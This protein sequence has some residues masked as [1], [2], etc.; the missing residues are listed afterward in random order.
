MMQFLVHLHRMGNSN[1]LPLNY[2]YELSS[3]IYRI[4]EEADPA[5]SH[6]LHQEGFAFGNK[7][8]KPFTFSFLEFDRFKI[9]KG[10]NRL[11][12]MGSQAVLDIRFAIDRAAEEFIKGL[13]LNQHLSI[14]DRIS[15]VDYEI[16]QIKAAPRVD[17][18]EEMLY[19]CTSPMF[20]SC[21][22]EDGGADYLSPEDGRFKPVFENNLIQRLM[23]FHV[24]LSLKEMEEDFP[25]MEFV[26]KSSP[27]KKGITLKALEEKPIKVI[28]YQFDFMLRAPTIIQELGYYGGFG[29]KNALGF[30][31]VR[32]N[33]K[34]FPK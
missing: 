18:K 23:S 26:L 10:H 28:G 6:F 17:F 2:Q 31:C 22:R 24:H 12:H 27:R 16:R 7:K 13:F 30:G 29:S 8:Y 32:V 21:S 9:V 20:L 15:R 33:E 11:E 34:S 1:F 19:R 5:Y 3:A 25:A 14:G 4:L